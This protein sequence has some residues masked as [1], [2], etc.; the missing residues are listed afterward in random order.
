MVSIAHS[1]Q[2]FSLTQQGALAQ[3]RKGRAITPT[4]EGVKNPTL[5]M[6]PVYRDEQQILRAFEMNNVALVLG[7]PSGNLADFDLDEPLAANIA[8]TFGVDTE[9]YGRKGKPGSHRLIITDKPLKSKQYRDPLDSAMLVELRGTGAVSQAPG[10]RHP[11]GETYVYDTDCEPVYM[12][13]D[14][15]YTLAQRIAV[16]SFFAKHWRA[17]SRHD[18]AMYLAGWFRKQ[19]WEQ[20]ETT[21]FIRAIY[22]AAKDDN[23]WRM[24]LT[25]IED[26][27]TKD[28]NEIKGSEGIKETW[29]S[30]VYQWVKRELGFGATKYIAPIE[31]DSAHQKDIMRFTERWNAMLFKN[32]HGGNVRYCPELKAWHIWNEQCWQRDTML[33]VYE[34]ADDIRDEIIKVAHAAKGR[35]ISE[36]WEWVKASSK[37]RALDNTPADAAKM[38]ASLKASVHEFDTHHTLLVCGNGTIDLDTQTLLPFRKEDMITRHVETE[39][40]SDAAIPLI[41]EM[42]RAALGNDATLRV[43]QKACGVALSGKTDKTIFFCYG[44]TDTGKTT[45]L[46]GLKHLLGD[47]AKQM[48]LDSIIAGRER[49]QEMWAADL[50]AA[51]CAVASETPRGFELDVATIKA[52][53]GDT[54]QKARALYENPFDSEP[55]Y[56]MFIDTNFRPKMP[57]AGEDDAMWNRVR[58]IHFKNKVKVEPG[59]A[60]YISDFKEVIKSDEEMQGFLA[61]CVEGYRLWRHEG[62]GETDEMKQNKA[63]YR[64]E[65]DTI[66]AFLDANL[67]YCPDD[68]K[69]LVSVDEVRKLYTR[70]GKDTYGY[71]FVQLDWSDFNDA[72]EKRGFVRPAKAKYCN[73][74]TTKVWQYMKVTITSD[75]THDV[76]HT[77][78]IA[79]ASMTIEYQPTE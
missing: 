36:A 24:H 7:K 3:Y 48:A 76:P 12:A 52:M 57:D 35:E 11:S 9:T 33:K 75:E 15:A 14:A 40:H 31:K 54:A 39:Y 67:E 38:Y 71:K 55:T 16:A 44:P 51:R 13:C 32:K 23:P 45:L 62:M 64:E 17:G 47:Y 20:E 61:W 21:L 2:S 37:S 50:H 1:T 58:L 29:D 68:D 18:T 30:K 49:K 46:N 4:P 8:D 77:E 73:S 53:T 60:G 42:A 28:E 63:E 72:L 74:K 43:L 79:G 26:A 56:T 22:Q 65:E 27:Y 66:G 25:A 69:A 70:W 78:N 19:G 10:S 34:L 59:E 6:H 5:K 41:V